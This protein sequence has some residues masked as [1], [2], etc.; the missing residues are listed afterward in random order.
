MNTIVIGGSREQKIASLVLE[1]SIKK[2]ATVPVNVIHTFDRR[3]PEPTNPALKSK[4][5]FS[6]NR[7]AIPELAGYQGVAAY[8]ECDQLVF[9]DVK[10]LLTIP[11][12]GATILRPE[13]QASVL[14][15]DCDKLKWDVKKIVSRLDAKKYSYSDLM[16]RICIEPPSSIKC[17]IPNYWNSLEKYVPG[18]TALLHYTNMGIQPWRRWGHPLAHLWMGELREAVREKKI[19]INV[20]QEDVSRG[21]VV[22]EV[23]NEALKW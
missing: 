3:F 1:H 4:T 13:N 5:G 10:E 17:T 7:F 16:E 8:L 19:G 14:L 20:I 12:N 2:F 23:L 22:R 21:C 9:R 6:F 11:F 15:L 18:E